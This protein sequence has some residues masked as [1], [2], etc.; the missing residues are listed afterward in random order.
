[1]ETVYENNNYI[2]KVGPSKIYEDYIVYLVRNKRT[3]VV[4]VEDSMLPKAIDYAV[5]LNKAIIDITEVDDLE[6]FPE[7][8]ISH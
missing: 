2:V 5:Q 3:D 6:L 7:T 4:E 8:S 1:M